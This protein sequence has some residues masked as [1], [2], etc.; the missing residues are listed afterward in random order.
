MRYTFIS[1]KTT[2]MYRTWDSLPSIELAKSKSIGTPTTPSEL[3]NASFRVSIAVDEKWWVFWIEYLWAIAAVLEAL[4]R[5]HCRWA[6]IHRHDTLARDERSSVAATIVDSNRRA[7]KENDD[8][9][10]MGGVHRRKDLRVLLSL[11][12]YCSPS[13]TYFKCNLP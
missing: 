5:S 12:L 7:E 3:V 10:L 6:V 13:L 2:H 9:W 1:C 4:R 11:L 8:W